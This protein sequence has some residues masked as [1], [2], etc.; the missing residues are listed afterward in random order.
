MVQRGDDKLR[1]TLGVPTP[2]P[3]ELADA[4][5]V[6]DIVRR[7]KEAIAEKDRIIN[8]RTRE[9]K[10]A[11]R[12]VENIVSSIGDAVLVLDEAGI[13]ESAN[14]A[15]IELTGYSRDELVGRPAAELWV[16][17]SHRELFLGERY[18]DLLRRGVL[19][20]SDMAWRNKRG[21]SIAISWTGSPLRDGDRLCGLVGVARDRRDDKRLEDE[22]LRTVRALAASVAHEIRNP[23][24]AIQNSVALLLRDLP[25]QGDDRT[26]MDIVFGETQRIGGIV[27]QFLNFARPQEVMLARGDLGVLLGEVAILAEKDERAEK[28]EILVR[29]DEGLP[30]VRFDADKLR[31]VLWNLVSNALDAG[32]KHVALRARLV[33]GG[34]EVRVADDGAGMEPAVLA[35]AFEPFRTTKARGTGLGLVICKSIVEAHGG[36]IRIESAPGEGTTVSFT[37]PGEGAGEPAP[38]AQDPHATEGSVR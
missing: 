32:G 26:L 14:E 28:G 22:K 35:R 1:P 36:S 31:Q 15:A 27:S 10:D 25:L 38:E 34:V 29:L 13:V 3:G 9:L 2:G 16:D 37:L 6:L 24:G 12:R 33:E 19:Q 11:R 20:R 17:P 7:L 23:L 8:E 5:S 18:M 21:D 30:Q 4:P